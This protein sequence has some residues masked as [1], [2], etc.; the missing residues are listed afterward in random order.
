M[1]TSMNARMDCMNLSTSR[2]PR[3]RRSPM[4]YESPMNHRMRW[5]WILLVAVVATLGGEQ[6]AHAQSNDATVTPTEEGDLESIWAERRT[7]RVIQRRL[8]PTDG[9]FQLTLYAGAIPNDP[10]V[11]YWPLGLRFG[12]W[13]T[14]SI[15][16]ELHGS[17]MGDIFKKDTELAQF[18]EAER[19]N[20]FPRDR[21]LYRAGGAVLW[22]PL[23]GKFSFLG[24]K[25]AHFDWYVGA[26]VNVVGVENPAQDDTTR[27]FTTITPEGSIITGW[28][29][30]LHEN[31]ALRL[32]YR[33]GIMIRDA[34]GVAFPSEISLG[35]SFFFP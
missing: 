34:G 24:T 8:Y 7:V 11:N 16:V 26:G 13:I 10:F 31:W 2:G 25:L 9:E 5:L 1:P 20:P 14:E 30:H 3:A 23:Y 4:D 17:F 27:T 15:A 21:Q 19:V 28:N 32:D 18:L 33:Q 29:L 22:S 6:A 12:Y 35:A